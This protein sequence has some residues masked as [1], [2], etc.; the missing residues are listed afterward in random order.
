MYFQCI[1]THVHIVLL[2]NNLPACCDAD[3]ATAEESLYHFDSCAVVLIDAMLTY[4][5]LPVG[6]QLQQTI[7]Q[8]TDQM[9]YPASF[10][11]TQ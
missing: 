4:E 11:S 3:A 5:N 2:P 1:E 7:L 8:E 10:S 9:Q 6:L